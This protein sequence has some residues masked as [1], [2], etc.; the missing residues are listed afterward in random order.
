[1]PAC[2]HLTAQQGAVG[3]LHRDLAP[4]LVE[5]VGGVGTQPLQGEGL[6]VEVVGDLWG[7]F[8]HGPNRSGKGL[9]DDATTLVLVSGEPR[10]ERANRGDGLVGQH[11][12]GISDGLGDGEQRRLGKAAGGHELAQVRWHLSHGCRWHPITDDGDGGM[13]SG[14]LV[15]EV[16][17]NGV[18]VPCGGGDEE[19]QV[20]SLQELGSQVSIGGDDGID[21]WGIEQGQAT[22]QGGFGDEMDAGRVASGLFG[23]HQPRQDPSVGEPLGVIRMVGEY[24]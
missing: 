8:A 10:Q 21:V 15:Q 18:G 12:L 23:A 7:S 11:P 13:A 19:P 20:G 24:R 14:G 4:R 17:R 16:P 22:W 6:V 9:Q 2:Q 1:M 3:R 5:L